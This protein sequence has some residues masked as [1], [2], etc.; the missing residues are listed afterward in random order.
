MIAPRRATGDQFLKLAAPKQALGG[1]EKREPRVAAVRTI[2]ADVIRYRRMPLSKLREK[3]KE[4]TLATIPHPNGRGALL[5]GGRANSK[6]WALARDALVESEWKDRMEAAAVQRQ[7]REG[8][9]RKF[10]KDGLPIDLKNVEALL[11]EALSAAAAG[12]K[13]LTHFVPCHVSSDAE[14]AT[15][16]IG[17]VSFQPTAAFLTERQG[18]FDR[19]VQEGSRELVE[20]RKKWGPEATGR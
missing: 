2:L 3:P 7:L 8:F 12:C 16:E 9:V 10:L 1:P 14:P 17:P 5:C 6:I 15:F 19:Y 20:L 18:D 4:D 13:I 11:S